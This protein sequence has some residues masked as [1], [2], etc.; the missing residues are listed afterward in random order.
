VLLIITASDVVYNKFMN[1]CQH[2]ESGGMINPDTCHLYRD[3]IEE[4]RL[5]ASTSFRILL[6]I[7]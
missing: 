3:D 7:F 5:S 1:A 6:S 4:A 2:Y